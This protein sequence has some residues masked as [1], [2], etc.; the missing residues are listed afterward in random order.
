MT[1]PGDL[2][3]LRDLVA[4]S[5]FPIWP[6]APGVW[7]AAIALLAVLA[8]L[9]WQILARYRANAYRRAALREL[10]ALQSAAGMASGEM[11][12]RISAVL[13]RVAL[14]TYARE[15]VASLSGA[16]WARFIERTAG[17]AT[18]VSAIS[19]QIAGVAGTP[20]VSESSDRAGLIRQASA[21]V[22]GH[23]PLTAEG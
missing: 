5:D 3:G 11:V 18:D 15:E 2:G 21:W 1:D 16:A 8:I 9:A 12:E 13:K 23:G 17:R 22:R 20:Q 7:I 14:V 10:Y 19:A 6:L 4:P